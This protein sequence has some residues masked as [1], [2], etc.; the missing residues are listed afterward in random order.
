MLHVLVLTVEGCA[1]CQEMLA[2][3]RSAQADFPELKLRE[4]MLDDEPELAQRLGVVGA[5]ALVVNGNLAFQGRLDAE[6]IRT[7]L[8]NEQR[9][10]HNDPDAYPPEDERD[11]ENVGQES[12]GS[13]DPAW[14]GSGRS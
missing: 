12:L 14:R 10:L 1:T 5:P 8:R 6:Q 9:G 11:P 4:R 7:Y 3:I 2:D 13:M